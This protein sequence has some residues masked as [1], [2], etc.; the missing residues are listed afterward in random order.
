MTVGRKPIIFHLSIYETA[1]MKQSHAFCANTSLPE[2]P[3]AN[4]I[5]REVSHTMHIPLLNAWQKPGAHLYRRRSWTVL[6]E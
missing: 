3:K 2:H 6:A 5:S 4:L 1:S